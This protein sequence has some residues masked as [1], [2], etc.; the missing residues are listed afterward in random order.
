MKLGVHFP[1]YRWKTFKSPLD[2]DHIQH[3]TKVGHGP[4]LEMPEEQSKSEGGKGHPPY[5]PEP[6][7]ML[8]K[9]LRVLRVLEKVIKG[10][11]DTDRPGLT[12]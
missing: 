5:S 8:Q 2:N 4:K 11:W 9:I 3:G 12:G 1:R 7:L 6:R 10:R